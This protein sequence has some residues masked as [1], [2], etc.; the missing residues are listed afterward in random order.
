MSLKIIATPIGN[1]EDLSLR[2][3]QSLREAEVVFCESTKET[4]KLLKYHH[5]TQKK[6]FEVSEHTTS[7]SHNEYINLCK[8]QNCVLVSDCGTPGFCDPGFELIKLCREQNVPVT[9]LPGASSLMFLISL[10]S[11][12]IKS[13]Y[14]R[15][16]LSAENLER[17][18]Q[19]NQLKKIT[20]PIILMDTP[21][22]FKK[23]REEIQN[24]FP[25]RK[26]LWVLNATQQT[27]LHIEV[28][29]KEIS[30]QQWPEKAEFMVLV[31]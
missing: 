9:A 15:G 23:M 8:T 14:F 29:G 13:F 19:L 24:A 5:I 17:S 1:Y 4:S 31:Y 21:Y 30:K 27:E 26:T 11:E 22:R 18:Q 6:Y 16:F 3:L 7:E 20:E 10:A 28:F 12:K 2:A 25:N